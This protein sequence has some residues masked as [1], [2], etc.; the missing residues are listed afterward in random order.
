MQINANE[1][2]EKVVQ[3]TNDALSVRWRQLYAIV[4]C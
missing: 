3:N 2:I 4:D 1:A